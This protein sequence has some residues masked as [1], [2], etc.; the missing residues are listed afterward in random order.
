MSR[1]L[2]TDGNLPSPETVTSAGE[3]AVEGSTHIHP[4]LHRQ[5]LQSKSKT[6]RFKKQAMANIEVQSDLNICQVV[7]ILISDCCACIT[8]FLEAELF[9]S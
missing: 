8:N 3:P 4:R 6:F 7:I 9:N 1:F 5:K 2:L